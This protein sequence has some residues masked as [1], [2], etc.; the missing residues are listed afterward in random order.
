MSEALT[1]EVI[2]KKRNDLLDRLEID[3][4]IH[5]MKE[6]TPSRLKLREIIASQLKVPVDCVIVRRILSEYGLSTSKA[7]IHVYSSKE[8]ALSIEP[9]YII[10]RN[11]ASE[12][13]E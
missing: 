1:V 2:G 8:R 13:K 12:T 5:H 7:R 9:E 6:G 11:F 10:K 4:V 3:V